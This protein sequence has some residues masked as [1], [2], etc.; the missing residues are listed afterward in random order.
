MTTR[1]VE[2]KVIVRN[3]NSEYSYSSPKQ[4]KRLMLQQLLALKTPTGFLVQLDQDQG[5]FYTSSLTS[6]KTTYFRHFDHE[7]DGDSNVDKSTH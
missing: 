1:S 6:R 3:H 4:T 7:N 5:L 2:F